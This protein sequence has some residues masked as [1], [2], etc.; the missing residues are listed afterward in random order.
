[1]DVVTV[2]SVLLSA[3]VLVP[4]DIGLLSRVRTAN[5]AAVGTRSTS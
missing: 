2:L 5:K 4:V 3:S 1:M